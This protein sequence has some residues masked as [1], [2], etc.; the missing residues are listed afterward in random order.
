MAHVVA[1]LE[2]TPEFGGTRF[3]PFEAVEIRL[4]SE[5]SANDITLPDGIGVAPR[6]VKLLRQE[7]A[8]FLIA[9]V[10]RGVGL[11]VYAGNE[12][13]AKPV[14]GPLAI[15]DG[16]AFALASPDGPRFVLRVEA[17]E[18]PE[19]P[20][21]GTDGGGKSRGSR[22]FN[23]VFDEIRRRGLAA[24]FTTALGN[25]FQT[26]WQLLKSGSLF[27]PVYIVTGMALV[28]GW[29]LA[30]GSCAGAVRSNWMANRLGDELSQCRA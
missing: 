30:G 7:D 12:G 14:T 23:G 4:G 20:R 3:G 17:A 16:D 8:S 5:A 21:P 28:S 6:H 9:P 15:R 13:A 11:F 19:P 1:V 18:E 10:E 27:A 29:L 2:L 22:M 24:V 26:F 25:R